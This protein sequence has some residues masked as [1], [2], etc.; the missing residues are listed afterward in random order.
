MLQYSLVSNGE[1]DKFITVFA[2]PRTPMVAS[3][4]HPNFDRIVAAVL[5]GEDAQDIEVLFDVTIAVAERFDRISERVSVAN[6]RIYLDGD[7]IHNVLT[8][9][10]LR[11][12]DEGV[13]DWKPLVLFFEKVQSNPS[14]HSRE[15]L[16]EWLDRRNFTITASG[17]FIGYKGVMSDGEGNLVSVHAGPAIVNGQHVNGH[18]PNA[19]GSVVEIPRSYVHE[20]SSVGC[21]TGLHVGT[22]D[23]AKGYA[24]GAL[25]ECH[26]NPR[27]VVSVPTDCDAQKVRVCRYTVADIIDAEY[28]QPLVTD[29]D[30]DDYDDE[31]DDEPEPDHGFKA[32]DRVC[33]GDGDLATVTKVN[34]NVVTLAYDAEWLSDGCDVYLDAEP[35]WLTKVEDDAPKRDERGRWIE[36]RPGSHRDPRTGRWNG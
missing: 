19:V 34:G 4:D 12:M 30:W 29:E 20:D 24:S 16:F 21:S 11:F 15:Q 7:E 35:H 2:P 32:G 5:A 9:Q 17:D 18:V 3:G 1:G 28:A 25:L 23:Y 14:D 6:G 27:D 22:Y 26:V 36:G 10:I 33:D 8:K 31:W 13:D